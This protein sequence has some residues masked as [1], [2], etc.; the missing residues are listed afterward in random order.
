MNIGKQEYTEKVGEKDIKF[1]CKEIQSIFFTNNDN[2]LYNE[3]NKE[4]VNNSM[5]FMYI[6]NYILYQ[7]KRQLVHNKINN[8]QYTYNL[9]ITN[10]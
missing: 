4:N 3:F 5:R 8:R 2:Q 6:L 7:S 10:F 9:P 1:E